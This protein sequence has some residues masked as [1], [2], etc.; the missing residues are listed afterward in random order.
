MP[1]SFQNPIDADQ[2]MTIHH[3]IALFIWFLLCS[4][5]GFI[6]FLPFSKAEEIQ[7]ILLIAVTIPYSLMIYFGWVPDPEDNPVIFHITTAFSSLLIG[8]AH[9]L[10]GPYQMHVDSFYAITIIYISIFGTWRGV[11]LVTLVSIGANFLVNTSLLD[12]RTSQYLIIQ[13]YD[14]LGLGILGMIAGFIGRSFRRFSVDTFHQNRSLSMLVSAN[15]ITSQ[16]QDLKEALPRLAR[17]I[18]EGLP[19]TL[20][21]I[22]LLD[23]SQENL[24]IYGVYPLRKLKQNPP[25]QGQTLALDKLPHHKKAFAQGSPILIDLD[26]TPPTS[27]AQESK[28]LFFEDVKTVCIIPIQKEGESIGA[29]SIAEARGSAREPFPPQKLD[30][31]STLAKQTAS[32]IL[33][34]QLQQELETQANRLSVL[35]D[36]GK[37]ISRTIEIEQL[38]ELIYEQLTRVIPSDAYFVAL[39]LPEEDM[40]DLKMLIDSGERFPSQKIPADTGLSSWIVRNKQALLIK[41]FEEEIDALPIE[42]IV[43][44]KDRITPSWLGVPMIIEEELIGILAVA[45]YQ[46]HA[47]DNNDQLLL[48]QIAQQAA[49]SIKNARHH[50]EV[51]QQARLDS[52]TQVY[53][54]GAFIDILTQEAHTAQEERK[55]LSLIMLDID[56]F[57]QYNDTY[58]H[59]VGDEVLRLTVQ[60]IKEHIKSTDSVG[61]WGGEEFGIALPNANVEQAEMVAQRIRRT[62]SELP[63]EDAE[64]DPIPKPT[65][66]QGIATL[67]YHTSDVDELIVIADRALY[68]AKHKGRDQ[69]MIARRQ[70]S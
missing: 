53:N 38:L 17:N 37:A 9:Y 22:S 51:T 54:H 70:K 49:L 34:I 56:Y 45:S 65:I 25:S 28:A 32:T 60:A 10:L 13:I 66:S 67:P 57:K 16:T 48:E 69:F 1:G 33:T 21:I 12:F 41:N 40:L 5:A 14:A 52:L 36:V 2:M 47:F 6:L 27:T 26:K 31:L 15:H 4:L 3:R 30:L 50:R 42:P 64:G 18:A 44:G 35:Y 46:V 58:G 39:Y 63:L 23:P 61:R 7:L 62:L 29:I 24:I 8:W 59:V 43:V 19:A 20:C 11:V 55:P 68:K